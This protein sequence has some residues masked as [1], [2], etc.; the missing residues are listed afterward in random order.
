M[1]YFKD[2]SLPQTLL[3]PTKLPSNPSPNKALKSYQLSTWKLIHP[4]TQ[5]L[6]L[7]QKTQVLRIL[8]SHRSPKIDLISTSDYPFLMTAHSQ[9]PVITTWNLGTVLKSGLNI[10][11]CLKTNHT[12]VHSLRGNSSI[13]NPWQV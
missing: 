6:T 13:L 11:E 10:T 5:G 4:F 7:S 2:L 3:L 9:N 12:L 8:K 1:S